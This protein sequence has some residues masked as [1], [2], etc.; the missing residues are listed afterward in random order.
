MFR[1]LNLEFLIFQIKKAIRKAIKEEKIDLDLL[2]SKTNHID[3]GIGRNTMLLK[4]TR[5]T[6]M[7][8]RNLKYKI[9]LN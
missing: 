7:K 4:V 8:W 6:M 3:Y 9:E 5:Q 2:Y 1:F